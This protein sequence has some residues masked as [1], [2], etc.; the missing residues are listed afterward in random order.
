MSDPVDTSLL[1]KVQLVDPSGNNIFDGVHVDSNPEL[2]PRV[3]LID[4][5]TGNVVS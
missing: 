1:L 3:I 4:L 2:L 5:T